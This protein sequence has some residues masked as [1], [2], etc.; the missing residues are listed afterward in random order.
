MFFFFAHSRKPC[1]IERHSAGDE[2]TRHLLYTA[3]RDFGVPSRVP[4]SADPGAHSATTRFVSRFLCVCVCMC[5]Y[6][7]V[8]VCVCV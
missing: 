1:K 2:S 4:F 7:C 5:V 3:Y 6:V 8:Y